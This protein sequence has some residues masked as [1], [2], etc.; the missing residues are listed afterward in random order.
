MRYEMGKEIIFESKDLLDVIWSDAPE[1]KI[2]V[3]EFCIEVRQVQL[4]PVWIEQVEI[5]EN[6]ATTGTD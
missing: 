6:L 4:Q 3:S 2:H 5:P 1:S